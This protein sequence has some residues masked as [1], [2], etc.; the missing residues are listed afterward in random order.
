LVDVTHAPDATAGFVAVRVRAGDF[1]VGDDFVVPIDDVERAIG[2]EVDRDGAK[3]LV[4][5]CN[6]VGEF[7]VRVARTVGGGR[8]AD[9]VDRV[10]DRIGEEE[11]LRT[12]GGGRAVA[13]EKAVAIFGEREAVRCGSAR[14]PAD[15]VG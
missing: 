12:I 11:D 15:S 9:S 10:G 2:A 7:F 14:W 5:G 6:K 1:V 4:G 3:P 8:G 13:A